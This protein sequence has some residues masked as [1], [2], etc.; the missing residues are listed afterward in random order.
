M[1]EE[2]VLRERIPDP[3]SYAK[4]KLNG[5]GNSDIGDIRNIIISGNQLKCIRINVYEFLIKIE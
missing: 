5:I 2:E 4:M 1:D 3:K